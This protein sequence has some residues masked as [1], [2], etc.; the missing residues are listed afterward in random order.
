[1]PLRRSAAAEA[2]L[3]CARVQPV[4]VST[5]ISR[6]IDEVFDYLVDIANHAEFSDHYLA[7]WHLTR[8]DTIGRGAGARFRLKQKRN[9]F[10]WADVTFVEVQE[11]R[12]IVA[13]G[14]IG[15]YNRNRMVGVYELQPLAHDSTRVIFTLETEPK[16]PSDRLLEALFGKRFLSR[17]MKKAMRRLRTILEEDRDRGARATVSGGARKPASN[18]R[19]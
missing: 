7:D 10:P 17:G 2:P 13:A 9:R 11:P 14:R 18:F 19:L 6:P 1:M 5:V 3:D 15:K 16:L 4:S 8:E 12:R